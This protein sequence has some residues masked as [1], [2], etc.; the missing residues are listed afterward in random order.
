MSQLAWTPLTDG[1]L[2]ALVPLAQACLDRD[3]GLPDLATPARLELA[4]RQP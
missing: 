3:G 4:L 1:D 2:E